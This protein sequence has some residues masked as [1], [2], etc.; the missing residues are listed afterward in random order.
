VNGEKLPNVYRIADQL[1]GHKTSE[2][3]YSTLLLFFGQFVAHDLTFLATTVGENKR[4]IVCSCG[5]SIKD[6]STDACFNIEGSV[7]DYLNTHTCTPLVRSAGAVGHFDCRLGKRDQI[8]MVTHWLDASPLYGSDI[9]TATSLRT[10]SNGF[11]KFDKANT[12]YFTLP[13]RPEKN[14]NCSI[15]CYSAGD[16]RAEENIYLTAV[17]TIWLREHNRIARSLARINRNWNDEK[18]F[19]EARRI[20]IAEYQ[21]ITF[22]E[23]LPLVIGERITKKYDLFSLKKGYLDNYNDSVYPSILNEF[24]TSA[25][26]LHNLIRSKTCKADINYAKSSC[27][28]I[29]SNMLNSS[30][31]TSETEFIIRAMLTDRLY[32]WMPQI[33]DDLNK[34]L[35][36]AKLSLGALNIQRGRDHGLRSYNDYRENCGLGRANSF[37]DL[38]NIPRKTLEILKT[39]YSHVDDIDLYVGGISEY[40]IIDGIVGETFGC[41]K[42]K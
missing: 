2:S 11:L 29:G 4:P 10:F 12:L 6:C 8:N 13:F 36:N 34:N 38:K 14:Q 16:S 40:S 39:L 35:F 42:Y 32:Y 21:H 1:M 31:I 3:E 24:A 19:H 30:V 33:N 17:Q 25:F 5:K 9:E 41:K 26:R 23:F 18:I 15:N 37:E 27:S 7:D 28:N 22:N 20:V